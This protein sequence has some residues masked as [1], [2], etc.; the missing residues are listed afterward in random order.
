[1]QEQNASSGEFLCAH[2]DVVE[3]VTSYLPADEILYDLAE[4]FKV[5][6]DST[7]IKI[8]YV[9][10]ESEM[11]VGDIAQLLKLTQTAVSHQLRV[12]KNN[13]L[14]KFRREGKVVFY[15][16]AD[17]HVR[18]IIGQGMEHIGE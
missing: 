8:L 18:S 1:M 12:L 14:V 5:F 9:L 16:L 3:R 6:G 11:C 2:D 13:K 10:F 4:L 7:R 17:D 15:S